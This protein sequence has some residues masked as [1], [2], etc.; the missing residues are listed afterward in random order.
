MTESLLA[1]R[2]KTSLELNGS[3]K[4][5]NAAGDSFTAAMGYHQSLQLWP[6]CPTTRLAMAEKLR[7]AASTEVRAGICVF[8]D[9]HPATIRLSVDYPLIS[10]FPLI[11]VDF[12]WLPSGANP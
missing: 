12:R 6:K 10:V 5:H 3:S 9:Y 8:V 7:G 2:Y 1:W 4:E 11:S